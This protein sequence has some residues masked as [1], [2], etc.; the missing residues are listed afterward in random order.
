MM[1]R[2]TVTSA[3]CVVL[4][5]SSVHTGDIYLASQEGKRVKNM[6]DDNI[7]MF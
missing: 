7:L 6:E 2:D 5:A 3:A 1:L 4:I